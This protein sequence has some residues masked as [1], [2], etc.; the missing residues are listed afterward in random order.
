NDAV[1]GA[2]SADPGVHRLTDGFP[3]WRVIAGTLVRQQG[4]AEYPH[5]AGVRLG[6]QVPVP[7]DDPGRGE[8]G[9]HVPRADAEPDVVDP[10]QHDDVPHT[11]LVQGIP[12]EPR[13][14]A[15][16]AAPRRGQQPVATDPLVDHRECRADYRTQSPG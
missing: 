11:G 5:A 4:R 10:L 15:G 12:G 16:P 6:D 8:P 1:E 13:L 3:R 9:V 2:A 14:R 7:G